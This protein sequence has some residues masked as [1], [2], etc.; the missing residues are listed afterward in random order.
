MW[1]GSGCRGRGECALV[2]EKGEGGWP[3]VGAEEKGRWSGYGQSWEGEGGAE[4]RIVS[5]T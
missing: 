3:R 1:W 5:D 2:Q 4:P